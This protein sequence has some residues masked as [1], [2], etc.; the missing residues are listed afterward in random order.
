MKINYG[1]QI[2]N[3]GRCEWLIENPQPRRGVILV[4]WGAAKRSPR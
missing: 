3:Y 2:K 1:L 4:A